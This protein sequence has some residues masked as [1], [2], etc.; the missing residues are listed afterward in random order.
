MAEC[1]AC[2]QVVETAGARERC[3]YT[4]CYWCATERA[5]PHLGW[6]A[7]VAAC[8][9]GR[10]CRSLSCVRTQRGE[11]VAAVRA[12]AGG[13]R[14][15]GAGA[16]LGR[17]RLQRAA[18]GA[19][20]AA[21]QRRRAARARGGVGLPCLPGTA[22][23]R[24]FRGARVRPRHHAALPL[25]PARVHARRHPAPG[26]RAAV[27][28]AVGAARARHGRGVGSVRAQAVPPGRR[29]GLPAPLRVRP[30]PQYARPAH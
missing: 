13:G 25:R 9:Q 16:L 6:R 27:H 24:V 21:A 30:Q 4:A 3:A 10:E 7:L 14:R 17:V 11:R 2:R 15:R 8:A 12:P 28:A 5:V 1:D 29:R 20:V 26:P 18:L 22:L 19:A 23:L